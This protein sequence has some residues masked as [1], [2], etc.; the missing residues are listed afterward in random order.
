MH[1]APLFA[2]FFGEAGTWAAWEAFLA[3]LFGLPM[4]AAQRA[5]YRTHTARQRA[6]VAPAREGWV[7]VGRRGGKSL[8]AALIAVFLAV[9]RSYEDIL[10]PGERGTVVIIAADRRQARTVLRYV[11]G[12]IDGVRCSPAWS[13]TGRPSRSSWG[14]ASSSKCTRH[15]SG[16]SAGTPSSRRSSTRSR[17]GASTTPRTRIGRS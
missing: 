14:A 4:S 5:L 11:T 16:A 9:F 17:S 15:R 6:P 10:A 8:I 7:V 2:T 12:L 3:A 1:A 13:S